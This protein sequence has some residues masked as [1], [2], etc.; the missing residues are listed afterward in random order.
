MSAT[1][2]YPETASLAKA[3][4][5]RS[6]G[7]PFRVDFPQIKIEPLQILRQEGRR[8]RPR[9]HGRTDARRQGAA[10]ADGQVRSPD[11]ATPQVPRQTK[12]TF[13]I[14][15]SLEV[16]AFTFQIARQEEQVTVQEQPLG[17]RLAVQV[18]QQE[19]AG[20]V[21]VGFQVRREEVQ[22]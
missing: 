2:T 17:Q 21:Q 22:I 15:F 9:R 13:Q 8:R 16:L 20:T 4:V 11:V 5:S 14:A 3:A 19:F 6:S 7:A 18:R 1:F 12:V 10:G